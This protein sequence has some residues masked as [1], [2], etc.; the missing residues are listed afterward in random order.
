MKRDWDLLRWLLNQAQVFQGG[1]PIVLT[2]GAIYQGRHC[3]L[4]IGERNFELSARRTP[5]SSV[6]VG[7]SRFRV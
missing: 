4:D 1:Y 7:V 3:A 6:Q 2:N 5:P